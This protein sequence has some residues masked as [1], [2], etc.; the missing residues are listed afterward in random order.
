MG[1]TPHA[2]RNKNIPV[3][4]HRLL[5][6]PHVSIHG[7]SSRAINLTCWI[8]AGLLDLRRSRWVPRAC[9]VCMESQDPCKVEISH[10][11]PLRGGCEWALPLEFLP[12][13]CLD[14]NSVS[15]N[16]GI[17]LWKHHYRYC[18]D[19]NTIDSRHWVAKS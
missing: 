2:W 3:F 7:R 5:I 10:S 19:I 14:Q 4:P 6:F 18:Y 8:S 1:E 15:S 17:C 16:S 11:F 12:I 9:K 13:E